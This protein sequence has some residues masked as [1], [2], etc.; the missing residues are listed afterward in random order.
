MAAPKKQNLTIGE[1]IRF[2]REGRNLTQ[3]RLAAFC[4]CDHTKIYQYETGRHLPPLRRF[5]V[6]AE[7]FGWDRGPAAKVWLREK[8]NQICEAETGRFTKI[9]RELEL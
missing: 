1:I 8:L 5:L 3:A 2:Q 6:I 9:M 7:F 4:G